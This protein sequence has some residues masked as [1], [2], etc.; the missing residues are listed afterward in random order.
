MP[1][2]AEEGELPITDGLVEWF[3][4]ADESAWDDTY[5][6]SSKL[7]TGKTAT[8]VSSGGTWLY[9]NHQSKPTVFN[10]GLAQ[11]GLVMPD[12]SEYGITGE[13]SVEFTFDVGSNQNIFFLCTAPAKWGA[14]QTTVYKRLN[15]PGGT[16]E[17]TV[18]HLIMV[19]TTEGV[20][21]YKN[22]QYVGTDTAVAETD[23]AASFALVRPY[24]YGLGEVRLYNRALTADEV[25]NNYTYASKQTTIGADYFTA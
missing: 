4:P 5:L 7:N 20:L 12:M 17:T 6:L 3:N 8:G 18:C 10:D 23:I 19:F 16:Y 11:I 2:D 21:L 15:N 1:P 24:G 25:K 13:C 14:N 9:T 22:G